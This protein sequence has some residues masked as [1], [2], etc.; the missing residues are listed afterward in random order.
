MSCL[1]YKNA[2]SLLLALA[3]VIS[4]KSVRREQ[5]TLTVNSVQKCF[6]LVQDCLER[7]KAFHSGMLLC[8]GLIKRLIINDI[9]LLIVRNINSTSSELFTKDR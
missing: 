5:H 7:F 3:Q 8:L 6:Q 1:D 9:T 2:F 4:I